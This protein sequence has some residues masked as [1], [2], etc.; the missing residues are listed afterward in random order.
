VLTKALMDWFWDHYAD[1]ADRT[2]PRAAPLRAAD[3]SGLP[4]AHIVT[5]EFDPLRDEGN[6]Y[7]A[8][9]AA[10]GVPVTHVQ[11]RGHTHTSLTMVDVIISGAPHREEMGAALREL[12]RASVPA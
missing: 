12:F 1:E 6:A 7:A 9:L 2:N 10:A 8:A 4:P 11:A 5:C 3:L